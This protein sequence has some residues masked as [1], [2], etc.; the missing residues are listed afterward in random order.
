MPKSKAKNGLYPIIV[1]ARK[2][3]QYQELYQSFVNE[4]TIRYHEAAVT[5]ELTA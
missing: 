2:P 4:F 3:M 5:T 1:I